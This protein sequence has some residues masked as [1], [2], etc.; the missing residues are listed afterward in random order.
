MAEVPKLDGAQQARFDAA[1]QKIDRRGKAISAYGVSVDQHEVEHAATVNAM[2]AILVDKGLLSLAD[3]YVE[4]AE[5]FADQLAIICQQAQ[6]Q[7]K[8]RRRDPRGLVIARSMP[9]R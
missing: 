5:A 7:N 1:M 2:I 4:K 6:Q 8:E 3:L 9:K